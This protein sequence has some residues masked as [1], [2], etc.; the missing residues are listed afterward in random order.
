MTDIVD[1]S[2]RSRMMAGI[3]GK[4]TAPEIR[5]RSYLHRHGFRFRLHGR[6]LP[7]KPDVVLPKYRTVIFVHGCFWHRHRGCPFAYSPRGNA[8]FWKAKLDGNA[9]R[10][11]RQRKELRKSGWKVRTVWECETDEKHLRQLVSGLL[12]GNAD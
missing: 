12:R 3:K 9:E 2:T 10:D 8:G 6:Q 1:R 11:Q 5:V 7:G 4:N